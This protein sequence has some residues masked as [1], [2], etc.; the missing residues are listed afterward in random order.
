MTLLLTL[1]VITTASACQYQR[2][3]FSEQRQLPAEGWDHTMSLAF[4]PQYADSL[5]PVDITL[6]VR[7]DQ[8]YSFTTL[9]LVVDIIGDDGTVDRKHV[10]LPVADTHGHWLGSGFGTLY[11]CHATLV[12][13]VAPDKA[14]HIVV[15]QCTT[16]SIPLTH[17]NDI[18]VTVQ[19]HNN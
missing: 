17:V 15:W 12:K 13:G 9:Q 7:H 3:T 18:S 14:R 10:A 11:Q 2:S 8:H 5:T 19:P 6:A 4:T 16:D 1:A